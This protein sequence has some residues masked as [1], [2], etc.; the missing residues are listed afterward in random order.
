MLFPTLIMAA[1]AVTLLAIGYFGGQGQHLAGI[2]LAWAMVKQILPLL[3]FAFIVAG[4]VQ[5]LIPRELIARWV[6]AG[7]TGAPHQ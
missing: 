2:G 1:L 4:M 5:V 3:V 6:G 7:S